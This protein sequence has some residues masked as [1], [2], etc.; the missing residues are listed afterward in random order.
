[1]YL[2]GADTVFFNI[3][4]Y[5]LHKYL[6]LLELVLFRSLFTHFVIPCLLARCHLGVLDVIIMECGGAVVR[7]PALG[8]QGCKFDSHWGF[9]TSDLGQVAYLKWASVHSDVN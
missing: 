8:S 7:T 6:W 4:D 2:I 5:N 3:S 9:H 1:M